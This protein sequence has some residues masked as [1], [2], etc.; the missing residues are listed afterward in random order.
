MI[1]FGDIVTVFIPYNRDHAANDAF[2]ITLKFLIIGGAT[3]LL[4]NIFI[5][6][7]RL[8]WFILLESI[9]FKPILTFQKTL[10][11]NITLTI[12]RLV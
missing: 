11:P 10:L 7:H 1:F 2:E 4:S 9:W 3:W 5:N 12:N 8:Y 6:K